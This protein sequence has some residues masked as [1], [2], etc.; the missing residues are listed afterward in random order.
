MRLG[1]QHVPTA[2]D[3]RLFQAM[4]A[5]R[6]TRRPFTPESLPA[7][8]W[9][10]LHTAAQQEGV[11][12]R[13]VAEPAART[14]LAELVDV[15]DLIQWADATFRHEQAAWIRLAAD[16]EPDGI[17][18]RNLGLS[19]R[20]RNSTATL[21]ESPAAWDHQ[22]AASAPMLAVFYTANDRPLYWLVAGQAL[23]RV[24]LRAAAAGVGASL[25]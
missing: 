2:E 5:R 12:L 25:L 1:H 10:A 21:A 15:G 14:A 17:P 18:I 6:T 4:K 19:G 3:C 22:L 16:A 20:E 8:L 23:A 9:A 13:L 7:P 11:W 24:L